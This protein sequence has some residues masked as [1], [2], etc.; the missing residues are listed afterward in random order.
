MSIHVRLV[1]SFRGLSG[2]DTLTLKTASPL[3]LRDV[4][5]TIAR[6]LPKLEHVLID[7]ESD[8][9][10]ASML[11]LVNGKDVSVL[12]GWNTTIND[13]DEVVF[14]PVLHGG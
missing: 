5:K 3:P 4:I 1:G 2:K 8:G 11:V 14:V 6:K 7:H 13:G 10:K 12:G 9:P